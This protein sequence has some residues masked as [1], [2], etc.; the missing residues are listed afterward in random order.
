MTAAQNEQ[1]SAPERPLPPPEVV[2][3]TAGQRRTTPPWWFAAPAMA[4][5]AFV[6][7]RGS[8]QSKAVGSEAHELYLR[9]QL[10]LADPTTGSAR[11]ALEL[12]EKA[13]ALDA[14]YAAAH[15][16]MAETIVCSALLLVGQDLVCFADLFEALVRVRV[17]GDVRMVPSR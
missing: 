10:A 5:F 2:V 1:Q 12:F 14:T 9:G 4:L 6:V 17:V 16:G 8:P 7:L 15:A 11:T 13:L 3:F